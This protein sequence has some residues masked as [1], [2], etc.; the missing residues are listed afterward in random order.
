[1]NILKKIDNVNYNF[2]KNRKIF[3]IIPI[4]IL[5]V[6]IIFAFIS[7]VNID[8]KFQGGTIINVP[9]SQSVDIEKAQEIASRQLGA[10]CIIQN[11]DG[12][13]SSQL[14]ITSSN[15]GEVTPQM[16]ESLLS[17]LKENFPE[18]ITITEI[19]D[20]GVTNVN[21]Q[22]KSNFFKKGIIAVV[23]AFVAIIIYIGIRFRNIGG[24]S[25]AL[26]AII[27]LIHDIAFVF[28]TM[29]FFKFA[30]SDVFVAVALMVLGYSLNNTI[31]VFDRIRENRKLLGKEEPIAK[32]V[33]VSINQT[34][35]RSVNIS[36]MIFLVIVAILIIG[37]I[38][39]ID[40][41]LTFSLP[42]IVGILASLYMSI[43]VS[44]PLWVIWKEKHPNSKKPK[45]KKE[46]SKKSIK[47]DEA[48]EEINVRTSFKINKKAAKDW[49]NSNE[50]K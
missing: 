10:D 18:S 30:L 11:S 1:M 7:G 49:D 5:V 45:R 36:L 34:L 2:M 46:N 42:L 23:A 44:G 25:A 41:I 4:I 8:V 12:A 38:C 15:V 40:L 28:A 6:A 37:L 35:S 39:H 47:V 14:V 9:Y 31:V 50:N 29:V 24:I 27:V 21:S 48:A 16:V 3:F 32:I 33:N 26:I 13:Q 17:E 20:M 22:I 43:F 19:S